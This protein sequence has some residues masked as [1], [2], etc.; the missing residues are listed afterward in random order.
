MTTQ[1][2]SQAQAAGSETIRRVVPD[3]VGTPVEETVVEEVTS[4]LK[5]VDQVATNAPKKSAFGRTKSHISNNRA[6]YA[7]AA[8]CAIG[9]AAGVA[10]SVW[11][12]GGA[13][14]AQADLIGDTPV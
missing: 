11:K 14:A 10:Y 12:V 2:Q 1:S 8:G 9:A 7:F 5:S 4:I 3:V 13:A 6:K